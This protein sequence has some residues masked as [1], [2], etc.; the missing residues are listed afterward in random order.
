MTQSPSP[1]VKDDL[2]VNWHPFMQMKDFETYPPKRITHAKGLR[3]FGE[4]N[5]YYDTTSSWWCNILG[6]CHP[7][8]M[9]ALTEQIKT[10][11]HIMFSNFTHDPVIALSQQL[12]DITPRGLNRVYYSDNGSTAMEVASKMS[13]HYWVNHQQPEK[14]NMVVF[15]GSYHGDTVGAMSLSGANRYNTMFRSLMFDV[16]ALPNPSGQEDDVLHQ[17][18]KVLSSRSHEIAAVSIE[19][20]LMGAGGMNLS[21]PSFYFQVRELTRAH[22][23]HLI[24]DEVATGF[25]RTGHLFASEAAG[26]CP[27]FMCLSKALTNGQLP[28]AVTMTTDDVYRAFYADFEDEKTFYH[29]HTFTA[30]P[31]GCA[32]ANATLAELRHWDWATNVRM[33]HHKLTQGMHALSDELAFVSNP[34]SIGSVGAIDIDLPGERAL[35]KLAQRAFDYHLTLRPLGRTIYLYLPLITTADECDDILNQLRRLLSSL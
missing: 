25:G 13:L 27:D 26:V 29:G 17:L 30:N 34:R 5:W 16:I 32:I 23:V 21:S 33:L 11:D 8:I 6:H 22:N 1:Q 4:T 31:L 10:L 24:S 12:V 14:N 2:A 7:N 15:S 35:F 9:T 3:L 20:L 19:P 18:A 28:L